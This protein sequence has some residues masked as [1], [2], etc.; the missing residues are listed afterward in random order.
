MVRLHTLRTLTSEEWK[1][2]FKAKTY[3]NLNT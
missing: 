2:Y 3:K 1:E